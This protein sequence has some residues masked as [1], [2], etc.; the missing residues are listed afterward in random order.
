MLKGRA[1]MHKNGVLN[2]HDGCDNEIK[3]LQ[4]MKEDDAGKS[5][6]DASIS[7]TGRVELTAQRES[8]ELVVEA[9]KADESEEKKTSLDNDNKVLQN[10]AI[11]DDKRS[12]VN[13]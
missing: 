13:E 10:S 3:V 11:S 5:E 8:Q 2:V 1:S 12:V 9:P 6:D 7:G 4:N